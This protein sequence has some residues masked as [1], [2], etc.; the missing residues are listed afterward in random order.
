MPPAIHAI[1]DH[2]TLSRPDFLTRAEG[3]MRALGARGAVHLRGWHTPAARVYE[4]AMALTPLQES[5]GCWLVINDRLDVA[6]AACARGVQLTSRSMS[7]ADARR[8]APSI[9]LGASVHAVEEAVAAHKGGASWVVAGHVLDTPSHP[10]EIGR[11]VEFIREIARAIAI[12]CIA[13]GGIRPEHVP[14]LRAAGAGG[15]AAI[16]GIWS[17]SDAERA[18]TDY[19]FEYDRYSDS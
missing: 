8:C 15:V 11:G 16:R 17:A 14:A 4:L 5:T 3:V 13:I 7:I 2:L 12:P 1:T 9:A 19:L 18:A 10:G 6:L